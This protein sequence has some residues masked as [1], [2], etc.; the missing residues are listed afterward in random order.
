MNKGSRKKGTSKGPSP[1][2]VETPLEGLREKDASLRQ[3]AEEISLLYQ[4]NLAL[5][6]GQ[7]LYHALRAFVKELKRVMVVDAFHIGFYDP[8]T[9]L[10]TYSLFLNLGEDLQLPPRSLKESPG[11]TWEVISGKK[12]LYLPDVTDPQT[13]KQHNILV[14]REVGIRSYIGIPLLLQDRVIGV[15]SVQ[16]LQPEAYTASQIRLLETLATQVASTVEKGRL[17]DQL[18][19]ELEERRKVE[20]SL[21]Q[22]EAMLEAVTFAAEQFLKTSDWH[23]NIGNVLELL[24]KTINVSH[25]Y[26]F[27]HHPGQDGHEVSSLRYEWAA[28]GI[29]VTV[30]DPAYQAHPVRNDP[31]TTDEILK[32]GDTFVATASA[33]PLLERERLKVL[34]IK[35][36]MEAPVFVDGRWWGTIGADDMTEERDWSPAEVDVI[37]AAANVLG[38]AIKRQSDETAL[39]SELN[40]RRHVEVNLRQ[41]E[42]ILE[43][44]AEAAN[45]LL[46]SSD[47]KS[48]IDSILESLGETINAS[49][50]FL[51]EN[52]QREDGTLVTSMR[53]EWTALGIP[54]DL[55]IATYQN[56]PLKEED[57]EG[58]YEV[59]SIGLPY[60]GDLQ[61]A[62]EEDLHFL[63]ARGMKALLDVPIY[64]N[65]AWWGTI[66]FDD[67]DHVRVWSNAEV[68]ALVVAANI[69][70]A[71]IQR[72]SVDAELRM[73]EQ[74]YRALYEMAEKQTQE[75]ALLGNVRNVMSQELDLSSL[76]RSVVEAV[77]ESFGYALVSV[78]LLEESELVL[79]HQVGYERVIKR[80]SIENGV[81]GRVVLTG[82]P[83]FLEDVRSDPEFI[84]TI[85]NIVSEI[86][87]PLFDEGRVV[88]VLNVESTQG[89]RLT[90]T[91]L[92][93]LDALSQHIGIAI[94]R[95]RLYTNVQRELE[96]RKQAEI[97][98][99][100]LIAELAAKNAELERFT[101]TVSHDLKAPLF[102]IRG[103]LGY[104]EKDLLAGD[105]DRFQKDAQ[106]IAE[107]T[108][109]MQQLLNDLLELSRVGRLMNEPKEIQL[110]E[111][112]RDVLALLQGQVQEKGVV[113]Q[114]EEN[115][116]RIFA[117]RQR[118]SEVLQNLVDNAVKFMGNQPNPR[119]EIGQAGDENGMPVL[120][121]RD[122]GMG[123]SS[124]HFERVFGLFNKLDPKTEGTGIGL[125]LVKRIIEF[126]GGRIWVESEPGKGSTFFFTL[127]SQPV[128]DSVL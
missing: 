123:I 118:I 91:D 47:W 41:R 72:Q 19:G 107:A 109:K 65:G 66:G 43:V 71:A 101:Y 62:P 30:N 119:V 40:E 80:I 56:V 13:K 111:L 84:G 114:V 1:R 21:R 6:S 59:M 81:S 105:H 77:A 36:M 128:S 64:V 50:A 104:L 93:L 68:D 33:F 58:W 120:F 90:H 88:G 96:A 34:G 39:Q 121:V 63:Q 100:K 4:I 102:T 54:T 35:A 52:H 75:L 51:F 8:Q 99:E 60:L 18:K 20:T 124:D 23:V 92:K 38:A 86:C 42:S 69:L 79:Q 49:H 112:V 16:S 17:L 11:L 103:F 44:V 115:L 10:F 94:G 46:K 113:V 108:E 45:R 14:V 26:L 106:R 24:G 98:R 3:R 5:T 70:G 32:R 55:G 9:D 48:E 2:E 28:P 73:R 61:H 122:N 126:H 110:N 117:D 22:R 95:A 116:P 12:T 25:C 87:V 82:K 85:E 31:G 83:I 15:M 78:Y 97:E 53:F 74:N 27:E 67:V 7:D 127:P 89:V 76:L 37:R 57:F 125:A 29:K